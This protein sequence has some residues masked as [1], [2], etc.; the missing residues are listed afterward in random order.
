MSNNIKTQMP[1]RILQNFN[2][3]AQTI[4]FF[5][6]LQILMPQAAARASALSINDINHRDYD[7]QQQQPP[8]PAFL[9]SDYVRERR[10]LANGR[11]GLR[12]GK[13]S[14]LNDLEHYPKLNAFNEA[15]KPYIEPVFVKTPIHYYDLEEDEPSTRLSTIRFFVAP[16]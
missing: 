4:I 16:N 6:L 10:S 13:R 8:Q 7:Q 5:V 15:E 2:L 3:L 1:K 14:V 12:P 9:F 11:W